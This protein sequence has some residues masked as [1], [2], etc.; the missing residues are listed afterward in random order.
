MAEGVIIA[1]LM[2][3]NC[4]DSLAHFLSSRG[5]DVVKVR[6]IMPA[7]S[8][9]QVVAEAAIRADRVLVSWDKDFNHQRF[10]APRYRMLSRIGFSCEAVR[11][12]ARLAAVID[13]VEGEAARRT[14]EAPMLIKI[15]RDKIL[16]GR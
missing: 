5:H 2:D 12:V 11:A 1:F 16:I 14:V 3:V 4:P 13:L 7:D 10:L 8:P 15:G 6:E 9:D